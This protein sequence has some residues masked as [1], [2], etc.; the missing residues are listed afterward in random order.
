AFF[1]GGNAREFFLLRFFARVGNALSFGFFGTLFLSRG[2]NQCVLLGL[3]FRGRG[4][5][6]IGFGLA[7]LFTGG[8]G[9]RGLIGFELGGRIVERRCENGLCVVRLHHGARGRIVLW[10]GCL[11]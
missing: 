7:L 3:D 6:G 8:F 10:P 2:F 11:M 5:G 9:Q 1:L 4:A